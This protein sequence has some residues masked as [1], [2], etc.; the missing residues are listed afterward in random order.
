VPE[1]R[2]ASRNTADAVVLCVV[3]VT[4][5]GTVAPFVRAMVEGEGLQLAYWGAPEQVRLAVPLNPG[6]AV[7]A[8]E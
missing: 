2:P 3:M 7:N 6:V 5:N 8:R 1:K 4:V